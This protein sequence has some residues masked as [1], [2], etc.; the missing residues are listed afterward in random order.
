[1]LLMAGL[2]VWLVLF[3][4]PEAPNEPAHQTLALSE[5]PTGGDFSLRSH[6]GR[7]NLADYRGQV[8]LLYFGYTWCPDICPTNLGLATMAFNEL[9]AD[10]LERVQFL[11]VSV[12]PQ[13]DSLERLKEYTDYFHPK[14]LGITGSADEV[15][16]AARRYGAAYRKVDQGQSATGYVVD[17]S[18]DTYLIDPRGKLV[19]TLPHNTPPEIILRQIRGQL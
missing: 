7:M 11:F 15:A 6:Q 5:K 17:H 13:R 14:I 12:D 19:A 9:E 16:Q 3:W 1:V 2:L 4:N 10:E 18:A 8:V